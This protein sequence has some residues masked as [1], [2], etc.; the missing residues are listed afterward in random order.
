MHTEKVLSEK[1][2]NEIYIPY[3]QNLKKNLDELNI[4]INQ[5]KSSKNIIMKI[6][7]NIN[8]FFNRKKNNEK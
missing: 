7:S 5:L 4:K 8:F 1:I 2:I 6:L 3:L